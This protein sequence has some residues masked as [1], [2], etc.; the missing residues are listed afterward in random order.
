[1]IFQ[2]GRDYSVRDVI[3]AAYFG[4]ELKSLWEEM[5]RGIEAEK[6]ATASDLE[7]DD[8]AVA[9]ASETFRYDHDLITAEETERWLEERGLTLRDFG[10]YL[11]R[12]YWRNALDAKTE[13]EPLEFLSASPELRELLAAELIFSGAFDQIAKRQSWQVAAS[14]AV[15]NGELNPELIEAER[16]RFFAQEGIDA[17]ELPGLLDQLERDPSWFD[18]MVAV[19]VKY[20]RQCE[21]LFSGSAPNQELAALR[22][23]LTRFDLEIVEVESRDAAAEAL[24]CVR[25]DGMSME[26][27]ATEGRYPYRRRTILLEDIPPDLQQKFLS[28]AAGGILDPIARDDGFQLCRVTGKSEPTLDDAE[29]RTRVEG[30]VLERHFSELTARHVQWI[31]AIPTS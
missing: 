31:G 27:V 19:R 16:E 2:C 11:I 21:T 23:P 20:Q 26:E 9:S 6:E 25:E 15:G 3:D 5:L 24:L 29:V 10:D 13:V 12:R 8:E 28:I 18:E 17:E 22:L 1:M 14:R 30:R 7:A 4:G